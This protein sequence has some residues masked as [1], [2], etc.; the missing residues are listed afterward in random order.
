MPHEKNNT[1]NDKTQ[2]E[3]FTRN[4]SRTLSDAMVTPM[5]E[6]FAIQQGVLNI[7]T[8]NGKNMPVRDFIQDVLNGESSVPANCER[9]YIMVVLA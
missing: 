4:I 5:A 7:P 3:E 1:T 9:Q 8:F 6:F 2:G